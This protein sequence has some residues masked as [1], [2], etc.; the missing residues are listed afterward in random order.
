MGGAKAP[1]API[2]PPHDAIASPYTKGGIGANPQG[3]SMTL[4]K[5]PLQWAALGFVVVLFA[6]AYIGRWTIHEIKRALGV[7]D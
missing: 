5:T 2:A 6:C 4:A 3:E 1:P 7:R